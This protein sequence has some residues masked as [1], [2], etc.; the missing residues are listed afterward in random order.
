MGNY[1]KCPDAIGKRHY[2]IL[3]SSRLGFVHVFDDR[4]G[5]FT[6]EFR[7]L[8]VIFIGNCVNFFRNFCH[9]HFHKIIFAYRRFERKC[10]N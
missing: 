2:D 1:L 10:A 8:T 5:S 6:N 7:F 9:A 3:V 4:K